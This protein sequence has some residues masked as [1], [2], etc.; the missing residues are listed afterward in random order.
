M[1]NRKR[2]NESGA[3]TAFI[4]R[5]KAIKILQL[6]LQDFRRLCIL[7]GIY[8][9]EPKHLKKVGKGS[10]EP[11]T[12][13]FL[14]DIQFLKSEP[15][16]EKF[17]D[18][19]VFVRKLNT[20]VAKKEPGTARR[21]R[22][23]RPVFELAHIIRERYPTLV[24]AVRDLDDCL[25]MCFLFACMPKNQKIH[26]EQI[27]FCRRLTLEFMKYLISIRGLRKVFYAIQ[28]IYYEAEV[29][30]QT[31]TWVVP[32]KVAY[33]HP[34]DVDYRIMSTFVELYCQLLGFI[35]FSLYTKIEARYPPELTLDVPSEIQI[36]SLAIKDEIYEESANKDKWK[37]E[38]ESVDRLQ[39]LFEG[40][41]F[42]ISREVDCESM[43]FH[44]RSCG[45]EVSWDNIVHEDAP[46]DA[47][48][49]TITHH[50]VD[51][52]QIE[53]SFSRYY[54]QPQWVADC[55]NARRLLPVK[56]YFPGA[57]L[58]PHLSP[59]V[60]ESDGD[61][62]PPDKK[63]LM[64]EEVGSAVGDKREEISED[65]ADKKDKKEEKNDEEEVPK[66]SVVAGAVERIDAGKKRKKDEDEVTRLRE[67][68][69]PKKQK[70]LYAKLKY[71]QKKTTQEAK[72]LEEKRQKYELG[73]KKRKQAPK[74]IA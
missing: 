37:A 29:L 7:K 24:D 60:N 12:Y 62:V 20:A 5:G 33:E 45:G 46:Y 38:Q 13:Y 1:V 51:R 16:I 59:F 63:R 65:K 48:D 35:N 58:P 8:P 56:D 28:G 67:M 49:N 71:K 6:S 53:Q 14:K 21:L 19:K 30:G 54:I 2:K 32:H 26:T 23:G 69:I 22:R 11:K 52:K 9:Q 57:V 17:R 43:V 70:R 36:E 25:T 15:I 72:K 61:Y 10:S 50:I 18:Y 44:I 68:A 64:G 55:I 3:A 74:K 34:T 31:V 27:Q 41:R 40:L 73:E 39:S 4:S 42:F 66:M 47:D